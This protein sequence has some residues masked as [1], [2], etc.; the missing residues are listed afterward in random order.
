MNHPDWPAFLAAIIAEPDDDTPRLVAADFLEENG[1]ADRAAFIRIQIALVNGQRPPQGHRPVDCCPPEAEELKRR[2]RAYLDLRSTY[3]PV[4]AAEECAE[5]VRGAPSTGAGADRLV[6]RRGFVER[7]YCTV[8]EWLQH[9]TA[10]RSRNP[11]RELA[12]YAGSA[13]PNTWEGG[14]AALQGLASVDFYPSYTQDGAPRLRWLRAQLPG[15][16]VGVGG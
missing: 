14:L 15:T 13:Y 12:L 11:V 6:W 8:S 9:G 4:W 5:L 2:E 16:R 10:I 3:A 7:V 1:A